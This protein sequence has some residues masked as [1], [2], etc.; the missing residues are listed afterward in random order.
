M[1]PTEIL[2]A[3]QGPAGVR[4]PELVDALLEP[5]AGSGDRS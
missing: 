2:K 5:S 1:I 3:I 4:V